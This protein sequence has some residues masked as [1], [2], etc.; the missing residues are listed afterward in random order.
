M[1]AQDSSGGGVAQPESPSVQSAG[2]DRVAIGVV[3]HAGRV[4]V[5]R[6]TRPPLEGY[7]EFPGGKVHPGERPEAAVVREVLE[8]T[9]LAVRVE[10]LLSRVRADYPHC[11]LD[12]HFFLCR[13]ERPGAHPDPGQPVSWVPLERL[14]ELSFPAA[15]R[16]ALARLRQ[17]TPERQVD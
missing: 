1:Y 2:A 5:G 4:L 6:R 13:P 15:N 14:A 16:E 17:L 9:G 12:L 11:P 10:S 7:A 8:E 3:L